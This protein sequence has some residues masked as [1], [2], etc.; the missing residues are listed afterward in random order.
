MRIR[1]GLNRGSKGFALIGTLLMLLMLSSMAVGI[2]YV[3]STEA[4]LGQTDRSNTVA[5]Y[6]AEAAMEKMVTDL[7]ARY[8]S[9]QAPTVADL[10]VLGDPSYEPTIPNVTYSE[11]AYDIPNSGGV[12]VVEV[13]NI[14]TGPNEGLVA[15]MNPMTLD[16]TAVS[17]GG[18]EVKM[19]REIQVARIPVFQFGIFSDMDLSYVPGP[20]FSFGGRVHTN[21]NLFLAAT[22]GGGLTFDARITASLEVIRAQL[23]NGVST[24]GTYSGPVSIVTTPGNY[25][26][27]QENEGSVTGGPGSGANS[28]WTTLSMTT[29]AGNVRNGLTGAQPLELPFVTQT[30]GPIEIIRRPVA[31]EDPNSLVAADRLHNKAQIRV[32][33][34]DSAANLPGGAGSSENVQL[35]NVGTYATG[36]PVGVALTDCPA[37]CTYFA[38]AQTSTDSDF[39]VPPGAGATWPLI[40]GFLRVEVR[41]ADG[42][43]TAVTR[44][45]LELGFARGIPRPDSETAQTNTVHPDAILIFQMQA[46]RDMDGNVTDGNESATVVG[47]GARF[48][49]FP[50]NLYDVREGEYRDVSSSTSQTVR[51]I[52]VMNVIE[53]D[54]NNLRRWLEGT[55]GTSGT[56]VETQTQNGY[57]FYFSDRRGN[58]NGGAETGEF[59]FEDVI[60]YPGPSTGYPNGN[61]EAAEDV[62]DNNTLDTYG[63]TNLLYPGETMTGRFDRALGRKNRVLGFRRAL[64][65]VN[66]SLGNLPMPGFTIAAENPAYL[67]GNYNSDTA[68][69]FTDPGDVRASAAV[70][71]DAVTMLSRFWTDYKSWDRPRYI[72]ARRP[73]GHTWY[74][75][76]IAAGKNKTFTRGAYSDTT[77]YSTFGTDGGTHN[78]L[79]YVEDWGSGSLTAGTYDLNYVGSI[80][81]FWIARQA[82]GLYKCCRAVYRPP[83]RNYS[84]DSDF[85][86]PSKLPPGTPMFRD[87]VNLGFRQ[88]F[89]Q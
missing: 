24:G 83:T 54:V 13:R 36:V 37:A 46:D 76:A 33:L 72:N 60:N 65:V 87:I 84:F 43:Y 55:I 51:R 82:V 53:V 10:Q 59:G 67:V 22:S 58:S 3:A 69:G 41:L 52:G 12:P 26:D 71:A 44:E 7:N 30:V 35:A 16:V 47:T 8:G 45:W 19:S 1:N 75:A 38:T 39:R 9:I 40:D 77:D 62:N 28:S 50:I 14:S 15:F 89:T 18:G 31:G 34:S 23:A 25:R 2:A 74:R 73:A 57:I 86:D 32:L 85:L 4:R 68:T 11:F 48:N 49:W 21:G 66:G 78:F 17:A 88:I 5:Y 6:A 81:N 70:I 20:A 56:T 61:R 79:R 29:Y 64:K 63:S 42:T 27:L 80:A